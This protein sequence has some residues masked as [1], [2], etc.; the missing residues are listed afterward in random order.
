MPTLEI[1]DLGLA[2]RWGALEVYSN[3]ACPEEAGDFNLRVPLG[4]LGLLVVSWD[5][6][7]GWDWFT[8]SPEEARA[9][10]ATM[11]RI[12]A[13]MRDPESW[14]HLDGPTSEELAE[15]EDALEGLE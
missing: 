10:V 5:E 12:R 3:N 11:G 13:L 1:D 14:W 8:L 9:S 15:I 2:F 7:L 6:E 4:P